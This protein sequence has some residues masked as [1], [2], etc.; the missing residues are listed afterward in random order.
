MAKEA[1]TPQEQ[2][3]E[4]A[5]NRTE[6]FFENNSKT[7]IAGLI[8]IFVLAVAIFG[9]RKLIVEPRME[10]AQEMLYGAQYRFEEQTPDY[11]LALNG[12]QSA[13]GFAEVVETYGSTP[14]GN[15]ARYYAAACCMNLGDMAK[16]E[17][18]LSKFKHVKGEPGELINAM[19]E[20]L[21]GDIAVENGDYAKAASLFEKAVSASDNIFT[22]PMYLR[23][24]AMAYKAA[25]NEAKADACLETISTKYPS[26]IDARDADKYLAQ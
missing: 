17:Q 19:A 12:D 14:A 26:S 4:N 24:A 15:L 23:K 25:G 13:P 1:A 5:K 3:L 11:E 6:S 9:Y 7:V 8:A 2:A 10:K 16:A 22:A 21:K 18:Y 20:G